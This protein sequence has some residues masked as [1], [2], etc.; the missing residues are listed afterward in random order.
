MRKKQF[1]ECSITIKSNTKDILAFMKLG[2]IRK[3]R[4]QKASS[5]PIKLDSMNE[6]TQKLHPKKQYLVISEIKEETKSTKTFKLVPD[7]DSPTKQLAY[8]RA[9]QYLSLKVQV[10]DI[11]VTRPY[12][13][14][15][16]PTVRRVKPKLRY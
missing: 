7:L 1:K 12:S 9:G 2:D 10:N 5:S 6:L 4:I 13:I 15:S 8:F 16:S 11:L 3:G 14:S